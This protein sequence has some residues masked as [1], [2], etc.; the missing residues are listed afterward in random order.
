MTIL[1]QSLCMLQGVTPETEIRLRRAGVVTCEQLAREADRFFSAGHARRIREMYREWLVAR[2]HGL[3]D[4]M[5]AHLPAGHRVRVLKPFWDDALF[6]DIETDGSTSSSC[7]T[8]VSAFR[9]GHMRSFWR[10][11]DLH[12]FLAE[13]AKAKVL[14]SF[15]GKRFDT[16]AICRHFGLTSIPAQVDLMDEARHYG[17]RGGLKT[18]E[19][20]VGFKRRC[21]DCADGRDAVRLWEEYAAHGEEKRL[22]DLLAYN[23]DDVMALVAIAKALIDR[24]LENR[25]FFDS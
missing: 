10:G 22:N 18:V 7:I 5:V 4:W 11:H 12:G 6:Y 3:I 16:P 17:F 19:K 24:S 1:D 20:M 23:Q 15:N 2:S 14:V 9:A 13:W 25:L 8:C 21:L